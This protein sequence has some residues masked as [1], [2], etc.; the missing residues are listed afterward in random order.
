MQDLPDLWQKWICEYGRYYR[1]QLPRPEQREAEFYVEAKL[2]HS[3]TGSDL[4]LKFTNHTAWP[5]RIVDNMSYRY[6]LDATEII[7][8]GFK[9]EDIV[10]RVDRDQATMYG[11]EYAAKIS[12]IT[13][14]QDNIYYIEVTYPDGRAVMPIS[15]GRNQCRNYAGTCIPKLSD[16]LG[17]N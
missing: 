5:A 7:N 13:H 11:E 1:P 9:P 14:Y 8:A 16:R 10:V 12:P 4:S 15:E 17:R 6:Y 3:A 2:K